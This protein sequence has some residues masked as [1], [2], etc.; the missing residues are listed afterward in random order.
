MKL[1]D[2]PREAVDALIHVVTFSLPTEN[3]IV[4]TKAPMTC[5]ALGLGLLVISPFAI[6]EALGE[7]CLPAVLGVYQ[8]LG[9]P[10]S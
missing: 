5:I 6:S 8:F 9:I 7:S 3:D 1:L 2:W 4:E 10:F